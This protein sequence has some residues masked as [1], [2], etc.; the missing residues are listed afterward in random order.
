MNIPKPRPVVDHLTAPF[1]EGT[2]AGRLRIQRCGAC[3][4][5][6]F[7][8][9]P[10][11]PECGSDRTELVDASGRGKVYSWIV[12]RHPVPADIFGA[13]VPYVVA[14]VDLAEGVRM[15]SNIVDCAPE[16]V[17]SGMDVEVL[18]RPVDNEITLPL[19]RPIAARG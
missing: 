12:V 2:R 3:G 7:P 18:Y 5:H 1:W 10:V 17:T 6:R 9:G 14:L 8:P 19:F 4:H 13:D 16:S 11:C 15:P